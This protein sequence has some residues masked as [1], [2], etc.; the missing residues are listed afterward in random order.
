[1]PPFPS[2]SACI[3]RIL[4]AGLAHATMLVLLTDVC[5]LLRHPEDEKTLIREVHVE[6]VPKLVEDGVV[7]GGMLPKLQCCVDAITA[8]VERVHLLDG[9]ILHSLLIELF[10][11]EGIGT[12]LNQG[13]GV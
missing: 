6:D 13:M 5:G 8:G 7:S 3:G 4:P 12:M 10:S 11:D 2:I 1:M 9:R